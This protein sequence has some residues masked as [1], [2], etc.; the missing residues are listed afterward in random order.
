MIFSLKRFWTIALCSLLE[1]QSNA[2]LAQLIGKSE[3]AIAAVPP[4][5]SSHSIPTRE[6]YEKAHLED[7]DKGLF[8]TIFGGI[9]KATF[10]SKIQNLAKEGAPL[11]VSTDNLYQRVESLPGKTFKPA[12]LDLRHASANTVI[13]A[14]DYVLP[15]RVFCMQHQAGSPN[16]HRYQLGHFGGTRQ[17]VLQAFNRA[18]ALN[19]K[20]YSQAEL[21]GV[22]WAVQAG[23]AYDDM[24]SDMKAIIDAMIPEQKDGLKRNTVN[25]IRHVWNDASHVLNLPSL[26]NYLVS[27]LG[28]AG[29]VIVRLMGIQDTITA[30]GRDWRNLSS[31]FVTSGEEGSSGGVQSTPWSD[32][33]NGIY[34]RFLTQGNYSSPGFLELRIVGNPSEYKKKGLVIAQKG[35]TNVPRKTTNGVAA[36]QLEDTIAASVAVPEGNGSI[37]PLAMAPEDDSWWSRNKTTVIAGAAGTIVLAC[38]IATDGLCGLVGIAGEGAELAVLAPEA[39]GVAVGAEGAEAAAVEGAVEEGQYK[40]ILEGATEGKVSSSRQYYKPGGL[41]QASKDFDLLRP[42]NI[43]NR[44]DNIRTGQLGDGST[45]IVRG[46][47]TEGSPTLEIQP[48]QGSGKVIKIRYGN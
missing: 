12:L 10:N 44:G 27:N 3:R 17:K 24:P 35:S 14:G 20:N 8:G 30:T 1:F 34:G 11:T 37:Q 7:K 39:E 41:E 31:T 29:R 19:K 21:Q 32:L 38:I 6:N 25:E 5:A 2:Y 4:T 42:S 15:V 23:V 36:N 45:V 43:Q 13:P 16:G 28:D 22:S 48:P 47:S 40:K 18:A 9:T 33:G 46:T 26:E